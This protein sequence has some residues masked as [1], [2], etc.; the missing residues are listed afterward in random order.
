MRILLIDNHTD[1]L[2]NFSE[3]FTN[4]SVEIQEYKPGLEFHTEDKDLIILSGG[5]GEGFE[6]KDK[7]RNGKLWYED[8]MNFVLGC[9]KPLVGVC[10]GFEVISAA[11]GSEVEHIGRLVSGFRSQSTSS[12]GQKALGHAKLRQYE[13]HRYGVGKVSS[14]HFEV[15]ADSATG[16][17]LIKHKTRKIVASQFHPEQAGGTM[18]L[19][20]LIGQLS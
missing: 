12:K 13:H 4:H 1:Y 5:G 17:E 10:M 14:K 18:D 9:D 3:I 7:V 8:E 20:T 15:L 6:L 19:R 16:I 11:F 2:H